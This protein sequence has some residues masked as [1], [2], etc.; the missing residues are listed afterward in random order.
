MSWFEGSDQFLLMGCGNG[1]ISFWNIGKGKAW[2]IPNKSE[3]VSV[4]C[5]YKNA[6]FIAGTLSGTLQVGTTEGGKLMYTLPAHVKNCNQ[7]QWHPT[8]EKCLHLVELMDF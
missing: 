2:A 3:V 7:V 4:E 6:M 1:E 8:S 5:A